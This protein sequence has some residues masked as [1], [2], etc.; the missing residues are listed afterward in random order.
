MHG[1]G[2]VRFFDRLAPL[3]DLVM[4][5]ADS[6][7]LTAGVARAEG[8]VDHL[9]DLGG[10]SG[11]ATIAV[12][13]PDRT[14]LDVSRPMLQRARSRQPEQLGRHVARASDANSIGPLSTVQGDAGRIPLADDSVDAAIV[15]DAFHHMPDQR[16]VV[17]AAARVIRPG[18]VFVIRE[19]DPGHPLG[20]FLVRVEHAIRMQSAFYT[21]TEL[22]ELLAGAGFDVSLLDAGFEYTIVGTV[23]SV[24]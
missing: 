1:L 22:A 15:V 4:P 20:W 11:R 2:D 8:S 10:G 7:T 17:E 21:P 23:P 16:A 3:Y 12:A 24:D 18:G 6:Q 9:L 13:A 19:F 14:V 5:A